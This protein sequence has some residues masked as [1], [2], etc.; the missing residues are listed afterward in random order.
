[1]LRVSCGVDAANGGY[2][3]SISNIITPT[4]HL[5]RINHGV[6]SVIIKPVALLAVQVPL[7]HFGGNVVGRADQRAHLSGIDV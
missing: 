2:P 6:Y 5:V 7:E 3:K 4:D 1:M